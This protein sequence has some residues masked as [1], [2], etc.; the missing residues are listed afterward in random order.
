AVN[1]GSPDLAVVVDH[2]RRRARG[3]RRASVA[4]PAPSEEPHLEHR[5]GTTIAAVATAAGEGAIAIVR[6]S[7]PAALAIARVLSGREPRPRRALL[8]TFRDSAGA[9]LD[10]G[11]LLA[12]PAPSSYTGEDLVELH[13]H[14]GGAVSAALLER[15]LELG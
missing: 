11:L 4:S 12:F 10:R 5:R 1:P 3:D 2:H 7:G 13:A 15:V 8:C 6:I 9:P 14:G